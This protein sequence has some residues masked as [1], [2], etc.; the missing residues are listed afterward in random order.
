MLFYNKL[1]YCLN[2]SWE[3]VILQ[4]ANKTYIMAIGNVIQNPAAATTSGNVTA[5]RLTAALPG[6]SATTKKKQVVALNLCAVIL[7]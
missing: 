4:Q 2:A 3:H 7:T 6:R 1:I 5:A